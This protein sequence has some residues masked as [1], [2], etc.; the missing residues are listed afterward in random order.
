MVAPELRN[1]TRQALAGLGVLG[2]HQREIIG[3]TVT[4]RLCPR[5]GALFPNPA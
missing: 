2:R 5:L 1:K 3:E 4:E